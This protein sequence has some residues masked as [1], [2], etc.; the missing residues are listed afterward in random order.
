MVDGVLGVGGGVGRGVLDDVVH[1]HESP[2]TNVVNVGEEVIKKVCEH[3][4]D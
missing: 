1:V 4:Q 3:F 2:C